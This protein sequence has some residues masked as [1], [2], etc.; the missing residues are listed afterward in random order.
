[1]NKW[2]FVGV[3]E[4]WAKETTGNLG[5]NVAGLVTTMTLPRI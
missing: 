1:V 2:P 3:R 5:G 4:E